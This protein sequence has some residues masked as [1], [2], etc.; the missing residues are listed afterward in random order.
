[1]SKTDWFRDRK[2]G[3]FVHYLS[4]LQ[5]RGENIETLPWDKHVEA[6]DVNKL[7]KQL[8]EIGAG[9]FCF[10]LQQANRYLA[11]PSECHEKTLGVPRGIVTP[12]R[13]IVPELYEA[14]RKYDIDLMLYFTGDGPFSDG[15]LDDPDNAGVKYGYATHTQPVTVEFVKKWSSV[16]EEI[17]TRYGKIVKGWWLDG[18]HPCLEY[19]EEKWSIL[20]DA[21]HKGN[22]DAIISFNASITDRVKSF[23]PLDDYTAGERSWLDQLPPSRF[24]DEG[25]QWHI[26]TYL[27]YNTNTFGVHDGWGRGGSR[28]TKEFLYDYVK[29]ATDREGVVTLDV[30]MDRSGQIDPVQ[31]ETLK[32]LK[33]IRSQGES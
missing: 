22:P 15:P 27:G 12:H 8:H 26:F 28:F 25:K 30:K 1:M 19:D 5:N 24:I 3:I 16:L 9:Y 4:F 21:I 7:A 20:A 32:V 11:V 23:S 13:D 14:L 10:T 6:L 31:L 2:W 29:A 18:C 33:S 17:S